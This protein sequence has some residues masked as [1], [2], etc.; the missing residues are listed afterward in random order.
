[1]VLIWEFWFLVLISWNPIGSK[2]PL[3][4]QIPGIPVGFFLEF[5]CWKVIKLEFWFAKLGI[6]VFFHVG[7]QYISFCTY[8]PRLTS[9]NSRNIF[10][11]QNYIYLLYL[12]CHVKWVDANLAGKIIMPTKIHLLKTSRCN[13]GGQNNHATTITSTHFSW[14]T[15]RCIFG[16]KNNHATKFTSIQNE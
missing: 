3:P 13:F 1:M 14:K 2:I 5:H 12:D 15:S 11:C 4:F 7:T 9:E 10:F 16:G 8:R 6:L